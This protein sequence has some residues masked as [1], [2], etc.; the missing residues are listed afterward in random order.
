MKV[1]SPEFDPIPDCLIDD[2]CLRLAA[3]RSVRQ[4]LPGGGVLNVDRL[5]P[6][7]CVY[8]RDPKRNDAGTG[9]FVTAEGAYLYAPG[10]A[11]RRK[12]MR[13]LVRRIVE[14]VSERLGGFLLLEIW[15]AE[16]RML[17]R[18][19]DLITGEPL[20]P[21]AGFRILSRPQHRSV[22]TI[23]ELEFALQRIKVQRHAAHVEIHQQARNHPPRMTQLISAADADRLSCDVL[24]LEILPIFRNRDNGDVYDDLLRR[25]RRGVGRSLKKAFFT[26]AVNRT[27]ARPQHYWVLGRRSLSKQV[28]S[29][30]RQLADISGQFKFLLLVTPVNAERSWHT[31]AES[32]FSREPQFQYRPLETDTLLLKRKLHRIPTE[33][34]EDPTLAHLFRQTQDEMDRQITM[35]SDIGTRRFLP[36]SL[37]VFGGVE[38]SLLELAKDILRRRRDEEESGTKVSAKEFVQRARSEIR[39]YRRQ[40]KSLPAQAVIRD[41]MYSGLMTIGGNLLVGRETMIA[42]AR[43][44]ALIQHEIGTHLLTYYNGRAQPLQLL[45]VGLAG[46]DALQEGMAV[47][48]EYLVGGLSRGRVRTLA[49]RVVAVSQMTGGAPFTETF[50]TLVSDYRIDQRLAYTIVLRVY[51]G[52]GLT[53]DAV[54]LRGLVEIL[55]YVSRGGELDLLCVGKLAADHLPMVRELLLRGVLQ[56]PQLRPRYFDALETAERLDRLRG[57]R[58]VLD[59]I[60]D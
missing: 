38:P 1:T 26:F 28:W 39:Y 34:I 20:L 53:K 23:A 22:K 9:L 52:G 7:L 10:E 55:D 30:D 47:L 32:K 4:T 16:D 8:R 49:A 6:F 29:V 45:R 44:D 5:L 41:D 24:G 35:L 48:S 18:E 14:T 25:L 59:L 17:M 42:A 2:V 60:E 57:G 54:Y 21:H 3:N 50:Q 27:T 37:Q 13:K 19:S 58:T 31:F 36:G 33:Q 15:S 40:M 51:R 11:T 12:G 43:V 46:Y 56:K